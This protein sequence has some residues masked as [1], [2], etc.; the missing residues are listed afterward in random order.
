VINGGLTYLA[1]ANGASAT[2]LYNRVG[3]R[4]QAAGDIP[5]PD[6]VEQPRDA[7]DFS[8]RLPV[9]RAF[10]ARFDAKNLTDAPFVVRQG[11]VTRDEFRAGR[12]VQAGLIWRP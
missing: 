4:I 7:L 5:L 12:T 3:A 8:L 1:R 2:I 9:A 10:S 6:V 11:T